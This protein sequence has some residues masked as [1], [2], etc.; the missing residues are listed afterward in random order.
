[1]R[2]QSDF[3]YTELSNN[4]NDT[5]NPRILVDKDIQ[6]PQTV[7]QQLKSRSTPKSSIVTIF[8]TPSIA[9]ETSTTEKPSVKPDIPFPK[10]LY[11]LLLTTRTMRPKGGDV[12]Y[13]S[14]GNLAFII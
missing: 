11:F 1:M 5:V 12:T 9:N 14:M 13:Q 3:E 6:L 4:E 10:E 2:H 7:T 8:P